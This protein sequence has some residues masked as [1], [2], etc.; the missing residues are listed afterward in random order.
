MLSHHC[1]KQ[2]SIGSGLSGYHLRV[3]PG[4]RTEEIKFSPHIQFN[5][6]INIHNRQIDSTAT[7]VA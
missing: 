6:R 4:F 5:T 7:G 1:L 2:H 3:K